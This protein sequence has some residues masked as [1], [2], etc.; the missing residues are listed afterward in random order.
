MFLTNNSSSKV[1]F[2]MAILV[3]PGTKI[4]VASTRPRIRSFNGSTTSPPSICGRMVM[5]LSVLQSFSETTK[6]EKHPLIGELN[7][8]N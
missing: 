8:Q 4:S 3:D 6:S 5:L 2:D 7:I 1:P